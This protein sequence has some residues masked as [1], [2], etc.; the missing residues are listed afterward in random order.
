[1]N[2]NPLV[3]IIVAA[4]NEEK[5][6]GKCIES[7]TKQ[8]YDNI[9]II[10]VNDGSED[11]TKEQVEKFCE[12]D[13]RI[14]LLTQ[15]NQ[16]VSAARNLGIKVC[17]GEWV[18]FADADDEYDIDAIK[19][20]LQVAENTGLQLIQAG[21]NREKQSIENENV[22]VLESRA[23]MKVLFNYN[24]DVSEYKKVKEVIDKHLR[25]SIHGPY[26]K[27]IGKNLLEKTRFNINLK[28][29]EDLIFYFELL[30]Q[31]E[32]VAFMSRDIYRVNSNSFSTTRRF[33]PEMSKAVEAYTNYMTTFIED[34][35]DFT[36]IEKDIYV[37]FYYHYKVAVEAFYSNKENIKKRRIR[38]SEL[39]NFVEKNVYLKKAFEYVLKDKSFSWYEKLLVRMLKNNKEYMYLLIMESRKAMSD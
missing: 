37:S 18:M 25:Y 13:N 24:A 7:L 39:R 10:V 20:C 16:G 30:M 17:K 29:G 8:T 3:S 6:I 38:A 22:Y 2:I 21:L 15:Q 11:G 36:D 26:G 27:L 5:N 35:N 4:Y 12:I 23:I 34:N 31:V 14:L 19:L 9:E 32:Y 28:L 1:M 33:N